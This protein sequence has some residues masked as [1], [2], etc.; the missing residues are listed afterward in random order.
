[1]V[2]GLSLMVSAASA[3]RVLSQPGTVTYP[4]ERGR[5]YLRVQQPGTATADHPTLHREVRILDGVMLDDP[6]RVSMPLMI[7][8]IEVESMPWLV[9]ERQLGVRTQSDARGTITVQRLQVLD[10]HSVPE[11]VQL[12]AGIAGVPACFYA[13]RAD[14]DVVA[15]RRPETDDQRRS[16][17][18]DLLRAWRVDRRTLR[19]QPLATWQVS[20]T[21]PGQGAP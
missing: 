9:L 3:E 14:P 13:G 11:D 4:L 20:C 17:V 7:E 2:L 15:I 5:T 12:V 16:H 19:L 6:A 10:T 21:N 1:M 18:Q 8:R